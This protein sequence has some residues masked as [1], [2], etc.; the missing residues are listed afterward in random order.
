MRVH[1][2]EGEGRLRLTLSASLTVE[3]IFVGDVS[4][5]LPEDRVVD[6]GGGDGLVVVFVTFF[7]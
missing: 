7:A 4:G 6:S 3:E 5:I 1:I 2:E